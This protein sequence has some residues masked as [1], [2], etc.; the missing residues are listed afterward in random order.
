M[1]RVLERIDQA[2]CGILVLNSEGIIS[3]INFTL[4]SL[5]GFDKD[6][7]V[8]QHFEKLLSPIS[9]VV[10]YSYFYPNL[11]IE[12]MIK[13]LLIKFIHAS[14]EEVSFML[15]ARV[16]DTAEGKIID[17][18]LLEMTKRMQY[19]QDLKVAQRKSKEA[20]D[21]IEQLMLEI[22][23]KQVELIKINEELTRLAITD[24][25][26]GLKNRRFLHERLDQLV[27][28]YVKVKQSFYMLIIDIDFFKKVNDTFG[29]HMGD[30]VLAQL[31]RLILTVTSEQIEA[32][33]YGG[34]EF[35]MLITSEDDDYVRATAERIRKS[36]EHTQFP[37]GQI[38]VSIG[39]AQIQTSMSDVDLFEKADK[40]LYTSKQNGRNK[41]T[42][43][44]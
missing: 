7:I 13:E 43:L 34:E 25:L 20:Y 17:C 37:N 8:G 30:E 27:A 23:T 2:P 9:K 24:K 5:L 12:G 3:D 14:G 35:I 39:G 36:V 19:E 42:F 41:V 10:Y 16:V 22:E 29:H 31:A 40:A 38:T 21:N 18:V 11:F 4:L 44:G 6:D 26:T 33:R 32:F 1:I 15:S 28:Q